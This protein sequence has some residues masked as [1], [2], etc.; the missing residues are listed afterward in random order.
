MFEHVITRDVAYELM[1]RAQRQALHHAVAEWYEQHLKG[2]YRGCIRACLPWSRTEVAA[3]AATF[4]GWRAS[5]PRRSAPTGRPCGPAAAW[6][7]TLR[8]P[9][10]TAPRSIPARPAGSAS[11]P[12]RTSGLGGTG[13]RRVHLSRRWSCSGLRCPT[14]FA[15]SPAECCRQL[16][17]RR[18]T[19]PS[20]PGRSAAGAAPPQEY[21]EA[22]RAYIRSP[23]STRSPTASRACPRR[24]P[25][26]GPGRAGW[27]VT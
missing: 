6:R 20:R 9:R 8:R 18:T 14:P 12:R 21:L 26:A 10:K 7:V 17:L 3:K 4:R 13:Q 11:S 1:V 25:G 19:A 22:S 5:R 2:S 16:G 23:R 24:R 15:C 27:P